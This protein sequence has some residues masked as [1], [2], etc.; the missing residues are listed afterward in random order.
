M[1]LP[2]VSTGV[3]TRNPAKNKAVRDGATSQA[4]GT[5][6]AAGHFTG[7]VQPGNRS[8]LKVEHLRPGIDEYAAHG[9][10]DL[11]KSAHGEKGRALQ[12]TGAGQNR[13]TE[14]VVPP[15]GG[16]LIENF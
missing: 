10:V 15:T 11:G 12:R 14:E 6:D 13:F 9:V 4:A 5:M 2:G 7:G 3:L 1:A 16:P 8:A